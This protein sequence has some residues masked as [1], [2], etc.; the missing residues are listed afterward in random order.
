MTDAAGSAEGATKGIRASG[1]AA[2]MALGLAAAVFLMAVA[3]AEAARRHRGR[4]AMAS[5]MPAPPLPVPRPAEAPPRPAAAETRPPESQA[6]ETPPTPGTAAPTPTARPAEPT[7]PETQPAAAEAEACFGRLRTLGLH[8]SSEPAP[9]AP[10]GC[11]IALPVRLESLDLGAGDRLELPDRPLVA[12]A[13]AE[14]FA[15]FAR[16]LVAPLARSRFDRPLRRLGTGPGFECR[17]RNRAAGA[18]LSAHGRGIAIDIAW[19][20]LADNGRVV[21]AS[22]ATDAEKRFLDAVRRAACGWF[23]TVLGPGSNAAHADHLHL[24]REP[25]GRNGESRFCE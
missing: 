19:F 21:V 18:R 1:L 20:G 12:C 15:L 23:T 22:V 6:P 7:T 11:G 9:A 16:D 3:P 17:P 10:A 2:P 4:L 8:F 25:R 14:T 5:P 13:F 24:D